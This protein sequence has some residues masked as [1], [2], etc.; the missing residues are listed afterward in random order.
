MKMCDFFKK[1]MSVKCG[2]KIGDI[3]STFFMQTVKSIHFENVVVHDLHLSKL[4]DFSSIS[5]NG[6]FNNY[7]DKKRGRGSVESPSLVM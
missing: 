3:F 7:V 5:P 2:Q 4:R 1:G 6:S